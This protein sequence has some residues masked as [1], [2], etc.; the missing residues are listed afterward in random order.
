MLTVVL[1]SR[2]KEHSHEAQVRCS[3]HCRVKNSKQTE[4][5]NASGVG[6]RT[7]IVKVILGAV[8]ENERY[9]SGR[10]RHL[11]EVRAMAV[12]LRVTRSN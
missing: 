3:P 5:R 2:K 12:T 8:T 7:K 11:Y 9:K 10:L 6:R 4:L 1:G